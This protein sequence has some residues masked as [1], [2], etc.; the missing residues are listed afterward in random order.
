MKDVNLHDMFWHPSMLSLKLIIVGENLK[1]AALLLR[2][3][4]QLLL[5]QDSTATL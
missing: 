2:I 4:C 5:S 3:Y 1:P